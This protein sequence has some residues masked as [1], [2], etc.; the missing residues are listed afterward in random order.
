MKEFNNKLAYMVYDL[1][2]KEA[3]PKYRETGKQLI[4]RTHENRV[5]DNVSVV[6]VWSANDA[7][8]KNTNSKAFEHE[9]AQRVDQFARLLRHFPNHMVLG[10]GEASKWGLDHQWETFCGQARMMME[11]SFVNI[12]NPAAQYRALD[13][14]D[15][16]RFGTTKQRGSAKSSRIS[17]ER[18]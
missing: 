11:A 12:I 4:E 7:L 14:R 10:P 3:H 6:I 13:M 5:F 16:L 8:H 1:A 15:Q 17:E 18:R 9:D 2:G